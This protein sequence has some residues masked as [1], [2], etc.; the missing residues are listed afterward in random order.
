MP[1]PTT[2]EPAGYASAAGAYWAAGWRGILPLPAGQK[3]PVPTG[4]TGYQGTD[5]SWPDV[6]A[7]SEERPD[8]NLALRLPSGVVGLDVDAYGEKTGGATLRHAE[9]QWGALPP[10]VRSTSRDDTISGI[11]LYTVPEQTAL[12]TILTFPEQG[13]GNIEIIQRTHR[14]SV[15]WPSTHPDTGQTYRW[16][17]HNGL[18]TDIPHTDQ[19]PELP[20]RWLTALTATPSMSTDG[21]TVDV[22]A[23]LT[24]MP[25]GAPD[26]VVAERLS[27]AI[28]DL[29]TGE[30]SRHDTTLG[31]VLALLR[32][33]EQ[34]RP[35]VPA[36]LQQ[37]QAAFVLA[38]KGD[39]RGE[40]EAREEFARMVTGS[41]GHQ[42]IA[43]TP[44]TSLEE[45][46][47]LAAA[48]PASNP[49]ADPDNTQ[50]TAND[51][52]IPDSSPATA[53]ALAELVGD[54]WESRDSLATIRQWAYAR[55]CSPWAVLGTI[56][57]HA[58][59]EV[60]PWV[61]LPPIIGGPGSLNLFVALVGPSGTGKGAAEAVASHA[62]P[63]EIFIAPAGSGEGLA[64]QYA[65]LD[66]R[67][68][69]RDRT[70]VCFSIPEIDTLVG[71]GNRT[72]STI[73]SKLRSAFSGEEIGFSYADPTKRLLIGSHNYRLTLVVGV[74]PEKAGPLIGDGGGGTPQR[75]L[76]LPSTDPGI[77]RDR[78][79]VPQPI[80]PLP[81]TYWGSYASTIDIPE[82]AEETIIDAHIKRSQGAGDALD[83]HALFVR[84]KSAFALAVIDGRGA[85]SIEDWELSGIVMDVSGHTRAAIET[86]LTGVAER[87]DQVRG[88]SA[89]RVRVAV[90]DTVAETKT[91]RVG[92]LIVAHLQKHGPSTWAETSHRI[93]F[94]DR[95]WVQEAL[96]RQ[97]A[98]G[99]VA[100]QDEKLV[101]V[102][103][104]SA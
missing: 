82:I 59:T 34:H 30:G 96:E 40:Q 26:H 71:I 56:M 99:T 103:G 36:A 93:A 20:A 27:R 62:Y 29:L 12:V 89:G 81:S 19:L 66:K 2:A 78:P 104:D 98:A 73:L 53:P 68:L 77:S 88:R 37:L 44:S 69:V 94:R 7:W 42:L 15:A 22:Q 75:F 48:A 41:R 18:T 43:A 63:S 4:H 3:K 90:D 10:T 31:H 65:H 14:Y 57:C 80:Y 5:P 13:L 95:D 76:W 25:G 24:G 46:A 9:Q 97:L 55:M 6:Y 61:T 74:Q 17:D 87:E 70:A 16:L 83:G 49:A 23:A 72:G 54:F 101:A 21:I 45:L 67:E 32:A 102:G 50:V 64:H 8:G 85:M 35:G 91:Q 92:R 39:G 60:P 28:T 79:D 86:A 84:L 38:V 58:L 100:V 47:G 11:R 52:E 33:A 51:P 1:H